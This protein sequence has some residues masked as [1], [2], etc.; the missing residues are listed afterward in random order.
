ML[1]EIDV[2]YTGR[3][4]LACNILNMDDVMLA[5]IWIYILQFHLSVGVYYKQETCY[6]LPSID[7]NMQVILCLAHSVVLK[8]YKWQ[9]WIYMYRPYKGNQFEKYHTFYTLP[10]FFNRFYCALFVHFVRERKKSLDETNVNILC[11]ELE[12]DW[13]IRCY[14]E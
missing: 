1:Y 12:K 9:S 6:Y 13:P 7:D 14:Q 3:L 2:H 10:H 4:E 5:I 11:R 8:W